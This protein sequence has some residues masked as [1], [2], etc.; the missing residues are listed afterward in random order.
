MP[1]IDL[2]RQAES[3]SSSSRV[4]QSSATT[5]SITGLYELEW[6][7]LA[8]PTLGTGSL[9]LGS[10]Y[11]LSTGYL[12]LYNDFIYNSSDETTLELLSGGGLKIYGDLYVEGTSSIQNVTTFAVED[13]IID[14][15]YSG[16]VQLLPANAGLNVGRLGEVSSS[17][18]IW[19]ETTDRWT[20]DNGNGSLIN[21]VGSS[22]T[23]TLTNKTITG[24]AS[25]TMG[26]NADI[27]FS[28][29][30]EVLGLPNTPS[31]DGAAS[32]KYY[33]D[34][35]VAT[36]GV[37]TAYLRKQYTKI[38]SSIVVPDTANFTAV[39]ASAP[40]GFTDTNENDFLWVINGQVME[41][42]ALT[43]QQNGS[44]L[45]LT[46]DTGSIGYSLEIDDEII[47]YG[48]WNS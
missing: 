20:V 24:L 36:I 33:V 46:I 11:T 32:S 42:D 43:I 37:V 28:S 45:I 12:K 23:D 5:S 14:L 48:K 34:A 31:A 25:S 15:N 6:N 7:T 13:P 27:T 9:D 4:L 39:T 3:P 19:N 26:S 22:T 40:M 30:G 2:T 17:R 38:A 35:E 47:S 21:I 10:G 8:P 41:M 1:Q 44:V 16:S 29:G 18:L